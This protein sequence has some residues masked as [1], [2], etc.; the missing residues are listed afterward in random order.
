[1]FGADEICGLFRRVGRCGVFNLLGDAEH[2]QIILRAFG[3]CIPYTLMAVRPVPYAIRLCEFYCTSIG[4]TLDSNSHVARQLVPS[5][6]FLA[7]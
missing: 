6:H 7:A 5:S 1:M 2:F 3:I 4:K